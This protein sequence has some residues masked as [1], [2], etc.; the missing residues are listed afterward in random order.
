M[1]ALLAGG[2][3]TKSSIRMVV[4]DGHP[5]SAHGVATLLAGAT[6]DI[7]VLGIATSMQETERLLLTHR[8]DTVIMDFATLDGEVVSPISRVMETTHPPSKVMVLTAS[9]DAALLY[10][11]MSLG[12]GA[13][14]S[15][16]VTIEFIVA[17]VHMMDAGNIIIGPY[18]VT[19]LL[20]RP[21]GNGIHLTHEE[22]TILRMIAG[23]NDTDGVSR[24]LSM[25]QS[26]LKR[27]LATVV[28]K[29]QA[30]NRVE[31]VATAA[32]LGII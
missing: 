25:S 26:T 24:E 23:G 27:Q 14:L 10:E 30:R 4:A 19:T 7:Q 3:S 9:E 16:R 22:I 28:R 2:V 29:L 32:R 13:Y 12:V 31:A 21:A 5:C 8:P 15:K 20:Q 1:G 11:A 6:D 18:V 17:A